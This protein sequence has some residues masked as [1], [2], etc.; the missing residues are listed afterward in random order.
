MLELNVEVGNAGRVDHKRT[1]VSVREEK[2][3]T[4]QWLTSWLTDLGI[5]E[6]SIAP[7]PSD[8]DLDIVIII[9]ADFPAEM[10]R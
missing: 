3:F 9:G 2:P 1:V 7:Q 6:P 8:S 5:Q 10:I 4:V